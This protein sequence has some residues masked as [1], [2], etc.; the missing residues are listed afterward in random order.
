GLRPLMRPT[1]GGSDVDE[2]SVSREHQIVVGQDGLITIAG[3][4][5]TTYRKMSKEVVDKAVKLLRL[6]GQL[7]DNLAP[8]HTDREPLPGAVGWPEDDDHD[9]VIRQVAEAGGSALSDASA[10]ELT[11]TYGMRALAIAALVRDN[12]ELAEPLNPGRPEV[13]AQVDWSVEQELAVT[14]EDVLVRRTQIFFRDFD[15]GLGGLDKVADRMAH[16]LGWDDATRQARI[17][18]YR[19]LVEDSRSWQH[20]SSNTTE[21]P[22]A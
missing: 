4:K 17:D 9:N 18:D 7:P 22:A 10:R 5:L 21:T 11:R 16:L 6:S 20:G 15:Q 8:A 19:R 14:I 3:G 12:P 1:K 13:L 2:S